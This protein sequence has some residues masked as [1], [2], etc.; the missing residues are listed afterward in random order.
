MLVF[1]RSIGH[2]GHVVMR[3]GLDKMSPAMLANTLSAERLIE[4]AERESGAFRLTAADLRERV[5]TLIDWINARGPYSVDQVDA[6]QRQLR[7][8]LVTR[9]RLV[10]DRKRYPAIADEVI[11][12]PIFIVGFA[13]S[14]TTLLHSLLANDSRARAPQAWHVTE[15]SPPPG[16][17]P[18]VK[19]RI[20]SAQ[21]HVEQWMDFCPGQRPMHPYV[22]EGAFQLIEDEE[23]FGLDFRYAYPYHLYRVPT[24]E[25]NIVLDKDPKSAFRFHRELLQHLQWGTR[26]VHWVCKGPSTQAN[27]DA[28]FEVYPDAL[29]VWP[30]RRIG[31]IYASLQAL[32]AVVFDTIRGEQGDWSAFAQEHAE[33]MKAAFDR[34]MD[35][36]L[37]ND[38]RVM[39]IKFQELTADPI[40]VVRQVYERR[41]LAVDRD[42]ENRLRTWL[43][44]PEHQSDRYGR[45][46][47]S[48]EMLGLSREWIE[49]L[50]AAY[51]SRFGLD[52]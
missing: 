40:H 41:G 45:Y 46:P 51:S 6:M 19:G 50:F 26:D 44:D 42:F 30:H 4:I 39:H 37:I 25:P 35:N 23:I 32:S 24:L 20:A 21:R 1:D 12:K 52:D 29:C 34:M 22:D 16:A 31:E 28:L 5:S 7:R 33:G 9:L 15:P 10:A 49:D 11:A 38:P 13:R 2:A 14:G 8:L 47:Y 48:Y 18:V 36:A 17:G 3:S 43:E 27:L